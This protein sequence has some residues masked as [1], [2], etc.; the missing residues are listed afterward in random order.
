MRKFR[1]SRIATYVFILF[2]A[3]FVIFPIYW[4]VITSFKT[5]TATLREATYVP[6]VD[7]EPTLRNW[8]TLITGYRDRVLSVFYNSTVVGLVSSSIAVL[9]GSMA[10][11]A[12]SRFKF[13]LGPLRNHDIM[14]WIVSQRILPQAVVL[15]PFFLM[16]HWFRLLDTLTGLILI[17]TAFNLPIATFLLRNF[18]NQVPFSVEEAAFVDGASRARVFFTIVYPILVPGLVAVFLLSLVLSW[19]EFIFALI[20]S[21]ERAQT[22][23]IMLAGQH[24]TAG[25][26]W[27]IISAIVVV[28]I[29][30]MIIIAVFLNRYLIKGLIRGAIR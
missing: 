25:T 5:D 4:A 28:M 17:Y 19:N 6:W 23:P 3:L 30:P 2:W 26:N 22:L 24:T 13:K 10:A 8:Q 15:V 11:Y 29:A 12:L 1:F 27:W 18:V 20:M 14:L 16:L 21:F 7:F 9:F